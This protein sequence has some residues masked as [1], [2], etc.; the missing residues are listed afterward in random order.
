VAAAT[1]MPMSVMMS[2][3]SHLAAVSFHPGFFHAAAFGT[4][5]LIAMFSAGGTGRNL[6]LFAAV[7]T[8]KLPVIHLL[9]SSLRLFHYFDFF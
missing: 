7:E 9:T 4:G 2:A 3:A 6:P 5:N 1:T 8:K